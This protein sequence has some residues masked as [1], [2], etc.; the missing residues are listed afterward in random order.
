MI[1]L[2]VGQ[3]LNFVQTNRQSTTAQLSE[4]IRDKQML[5]VLDNCEHRIE[6]VASL[7]SSLLSAHLERSLEREVPC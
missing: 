2:T 4:D 6:D 1:V 5:L 3:A 7:V